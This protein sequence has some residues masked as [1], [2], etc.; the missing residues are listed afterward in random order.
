MDDEEMTRSE[1][2]RALSPELDSDDRHA[3]QSLGHD[4]DPVVLVGQRGISDGLIENFDN[5]LDAHELVKVKVHGGDMIREVAR[6][7]HEETGAQ[8]AQIIGNVLL[9]YREHP[10]E[11][12]LLR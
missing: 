10:E 4:L 5:Q 11:P 12:E 9:F 8:L 6:R 1:F 3:L 2:F 7:L